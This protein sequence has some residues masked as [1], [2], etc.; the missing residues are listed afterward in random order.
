[1]LRWHVQFVS[2]LPSFHCGIPC[3]FLTSTWLIKYGSTAGH[4]Y[5]IFQYRYSH[6]E[7]YIMYAWYGA[8]RITR[9]IYMSFL[10]FFSCLISP[11][12][13]LASIP[14]DKTAKFH[15]LCYCHIKYSLPANKQSSF[16]QYSPNPK[17][18]KKQPVYQQKKYVPASFG[19][20]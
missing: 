18:S 3:H 10:H 8:G 16:F 15:T 5:C 11:L 1:M 7:Y 12:R 19:S 6:L 13:K 20:A 2:Y 4:Q 14:T 9:L 17:A